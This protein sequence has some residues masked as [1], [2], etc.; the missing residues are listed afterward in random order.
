MKKCRGKVANSHRDK[1]AAG[2]DV[3]GEEGLHAT[4][5]TVDEAGTSEMTN[6]SKMVLS[7]EQV[8]ETVNHSMETRIQVTHN[9][10]HSEK[11]QCYIPSI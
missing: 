10:R 8:V 6:E 5:A 1:S 7:N 11:S 3:T 2:P 4:A 9:A